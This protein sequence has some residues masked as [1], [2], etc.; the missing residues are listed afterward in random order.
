MSTGNA[1]DLLQWSRED[2][3]RLRVEIERLRAA[4]RKV[5]QDMTELAD[6]WPEARGSIYRALAEVDLAL[7]SGGAGEGAA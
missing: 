4:L 6:V 2:R 1:P 3:E 7:G 5:R